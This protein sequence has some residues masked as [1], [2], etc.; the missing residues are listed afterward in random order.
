M[1]IWYC[2][3]LWSVAGGLRYLLPLFALGEVSKMRNLDLSR[4]YLPRNPVWCV[5]GCLATCECSFAG[6][7]VQESGDVGPELPKGLKDIFHDFFTD[8]SNQWQ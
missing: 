4:K 7:S 1:I 6:P 8:T 5:Y 3:A 2:L